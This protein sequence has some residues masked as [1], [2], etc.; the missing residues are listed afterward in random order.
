MGVAASLSLLAM[1][2]KGFAYASPV[3]MRT[4]DRPPHLMA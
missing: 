4:A 2:V 3:I 1:T